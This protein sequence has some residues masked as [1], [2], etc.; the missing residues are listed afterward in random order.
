MSW[1]SF[2]CSRSFRRFS[3]IWSSRSRSS[4]CCSACSNWRSNALSDFCS[5]GW[6]KSI[7]C[8][9]ADEQLRLSAFSLSRCRWRTAGDR[10]SRRLNSFDLGLPD[11]WDDLFIEVDDDLCDDRNGLQM[12]SFP[13]LNFADNIFV[14]RWDS[15]GWAPGYG[16][17]YPSVV[18]GRGIRP[19]ASVR[20]TGL[21]QGEL[22]LRGR[23]CLRP[24]ASDTHQSWGL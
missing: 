19:S 22:V 12:L 7:I 9:S 21:T 3:S 18:P 24:T 1:Q 6:R 4:K 14:D 8:R 13:L 2:S 16:T 15:R 20:P 17:P 5:S 23:G 11:L 10:L